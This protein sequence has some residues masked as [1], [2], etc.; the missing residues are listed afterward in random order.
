[1]IVG[2]K[3]RA[4]PPADGRRVAAGLTGARVVEIAGVGH[5]AHE[6]NPEAVAA[7]I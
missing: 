7:L 5:L 2:A 3:D 4:V 6:E 1:L